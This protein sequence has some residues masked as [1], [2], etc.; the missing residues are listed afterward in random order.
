M[1]LKY[2]ILLSFFSTYALA[3][4][5]KF[6]DMHKL[7]DHDVMINLDEETYNL[8]LAIKNKKSKKIIFESHAGVSPLEAVL[9]K[10]KLKMTRGSFLRSYK[11]KR[12]YALR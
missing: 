1:Y 7:Y 2:I 10:S 9:A 11:K 3:S 4:G 12:K 5:E 6:E 8:S